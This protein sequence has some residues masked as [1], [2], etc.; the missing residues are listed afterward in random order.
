MKHKRNLF[1]Y[2]DIT[3]YYAMS[4]YISRKN[5]RLLYKAHA[6]V[7]NMCAGLLY[8]IYMCAGLL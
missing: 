8:I 2:Q 4:S 7:V 1:E 6:L 3:K 5:D